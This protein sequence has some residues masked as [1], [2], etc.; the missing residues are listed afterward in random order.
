MKHENYL[1][2]EFLFLRSFIDKGD[3]SRKVFRF[4]KLSFVNIAVKIDLEEDFFGFF[5]GER[6][7]LYRVRVIDLF[8]HFRFG[9]EVQ[10]RFFSY[11]RP[12]IALSEGM[13]LGD[14]AKWF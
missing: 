13:N 5:Q 9:N 7:V 14:D 6:T 10:K 2:R 3:D 4:K 12:I 1:K 11:G 8:R